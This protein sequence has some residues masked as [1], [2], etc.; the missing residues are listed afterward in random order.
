MQKQPREVFSRFSLKFRKFHRKTPVLECLFNKV[1]KSFVKKRLQHRCF[2]MKFAKFLRSLISKN[3]FNTFSLALS[4]YYEIYR[5][6]LC[7]KKNKI[8]EVLVKT[9]F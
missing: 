3:T 4:D 8:R 2:P 7:F 5:Q 1:R 6:I 9:K